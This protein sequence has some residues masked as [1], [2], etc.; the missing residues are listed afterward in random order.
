MARYAINYLGVLTE[1]WVTGFSEPMDVDNGQMERS[2]K[3]S[4]LIADA[5]VFAESDVDEALRLTK[6]CHPNATK[7]EL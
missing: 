4:N 7:V 1:M 3:A 5:K 6:K 2:V